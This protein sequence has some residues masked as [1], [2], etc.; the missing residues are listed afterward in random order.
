ME[1]G[2]DPLASMVK[3]ATRRS[4][5]AR[6]AP[7]ADP[8]PA[9]AGPADALVSPLAVPFPEI[10]PIAGVELATGRA[11]FYKHERPDLLQ[12]FVELGTPIPRHDNNDVMFG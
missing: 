9:A 1:R 2:L 12:N 11:G 6:P 4:G 8:A 10:P 5:D 7:S 3:R